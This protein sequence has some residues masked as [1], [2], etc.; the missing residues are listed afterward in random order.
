[1]K[2]KNY[3]ILFFCLVILII[4]SG[5]SKGNRASEK[6]LNVNDSSSL[7]NVTFVSSEEIFDGDS[8]EYYKKQY[9]TFDDIPETINENEKELNLY[10][11]TKYDNMEEYT[12]YYKW[13]I[14]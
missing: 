2:N 14:L 13:N 6:D 4:F 10:I 5:C 12:A 11:V 9:S 1:M 7:D 8:S 3:I